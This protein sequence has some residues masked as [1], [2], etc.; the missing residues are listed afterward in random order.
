MYFFLHSAC[1]CSLNETGAPT[2]ISFQAYLSTANGICLLISAATANVLMCVYL[3][4][5]LNVCV[6]VVCLM[7]IPLCV[8]M[9]CVSLAVRL[10]FYNSSCYNIFMPKEIEIKT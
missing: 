7:Y 8:Y 9:V 5:S 6:C 2:L 3:C 1:V 10:R 4:V